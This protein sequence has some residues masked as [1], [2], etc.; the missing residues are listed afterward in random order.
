[1][2]LKWSAIDKMNMIMI[3]EV[4]ICTLAQ[5]NRLSPGSGYIGFA[6]LNGEKFMNENLCL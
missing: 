4:A 3:S 6:R 1:M 2:D 5:F